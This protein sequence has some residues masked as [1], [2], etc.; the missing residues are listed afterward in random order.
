LKADAAK[1]E[2]LYKLGLCH[3]ILGSRSAKAGDDAQAT[4]HLHQAVGFWS[5]ALRYDPY[6]DG[7]KENI[8]RAKAKISKLG[9]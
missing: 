5:R 6:N 8:R 1:I 3:G 2:L 4:A 9:G 7:A